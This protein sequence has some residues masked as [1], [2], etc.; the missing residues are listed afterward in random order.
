MATPFSSHHLVGG[1]LL[2][3]QAGFASLDERLVIRP[4]SSLADYP[5]RSSPAA[6]NQG[7]ALVADRGMVGL[8][9]AES[10]VVE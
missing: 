6:A 8:V 5:R 9:V 10:T 3:V 4:P 2:G 1:W 7:L